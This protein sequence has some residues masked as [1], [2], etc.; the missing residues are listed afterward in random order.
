[1]CAVCVF[2]CVF[3]CVCFRVC[4][5]VCVCVCVCVCVYVCA[6][7]GYIKQGQ[8]THR[9][10]H[11]HTSMQGWSDAGGGGRRGLV[12]PAL[13][14]FMCKLNANSHQL[15][16]ADGTSGCRRLSC[17]SLTILRAFLNTLA[18]LSSGS[19]M[20]MGLFPLLSRVNHSWSALLL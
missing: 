8:Y 16:H 17:N 20:G 6:W 2:S 1:V 11:T 18:M 15:V 10:T 5:G 14:S 12:R 9:Y 4:F 13:V 19:P 3:W 7:D